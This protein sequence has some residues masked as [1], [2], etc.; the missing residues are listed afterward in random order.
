M[1]AVAYNG[2]MRAGV[3][4]AIFIMTCGVF[5]ASQAQLYVP[6]NGQTET[7]KV[8]FFFD[9]FR[10]KPKM[11]QKTLN[12]SGD[13]TEDFPHGAAG[14]DITYDIPDTDIEFKPWT[15]PPLTEAQKTLRTRTPRKTTCTPDERKIYNALIQY[16]N[17]FDR[18]ILPSARGRPL[19]ATQTDSYQQIEKYMLNEN[20]RKYLSLIA[21]KCTPQ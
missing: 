3:F 20:G 18:N 13:R 4:F 8:P 2:N 15:P 10:K 6:R 17:V 7:K 21:Y 5:T 12:P 11:V 1:S 9:W 19:R 16:G 14:T